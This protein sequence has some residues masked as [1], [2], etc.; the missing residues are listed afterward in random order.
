MKKLP[1]EVRLIEVESLEFA[2]KDIIRIKHWNDFLWLLGTGTVVYKLNHCYYI[3][4]S[5]VAWQYE[6]ER[7]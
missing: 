1:K 3:I 5:E 2:G 6:E 7:T 4:A